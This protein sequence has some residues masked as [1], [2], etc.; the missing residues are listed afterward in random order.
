MLEQNCANRDWI[1]LAIACDNFAL[2]PEAQENICLGLL[3][4]G[5]AI[6]ADFIVTNLP[7]EE[8]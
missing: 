2:M 5:V 8:S 6:M 4:T 1:G 7:F 3:L